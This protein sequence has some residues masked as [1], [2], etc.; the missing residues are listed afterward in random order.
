MAIRLPI[1]EAAAWVAAQIPPVYTEVHYT[2]ALATEL[3][4]RGVVCNTEAQAPSWFIDSRATSHVLTNDRIDILT[5]LPEICIIEVKRGTP[6]NKKIEEA[7]EQVTR[8]MYNMRKS[9]T[10]VLCAYIV[11]FKPTCGD[12]SVHIVEDIPPITP[13]S[14]LKN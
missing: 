10:I 8:Y 4:A 12:Y 1:Q 7:R 3:K 9:G 14:P 6:T 13:P 2:K 11:F 5:T